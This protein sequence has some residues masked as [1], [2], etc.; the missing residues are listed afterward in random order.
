MESLG[1]ILARVMGEGGLEGRL[2]HET[3]FRSWPRVVGPLLARRCWPVS[4]KKGVL[5]VRV[6]GPLWMQELQFQKRDL[7]ERV[8]ELAGGDQIV[9]IRFTLRG[10]R[11]SAS[12]RA[13]ASAQEPLEISLSHEQRQWVENTV[14]EIQDP[15]LKARLK[16]ILEHHL[17][18][19]QRR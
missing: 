8:A 15:A 1:E 12:R 18:A 9:D 19:R 3:L 10:V 4:V 17:K 16:R 13:M 2:K 11:S 14:E 6:A 5:L 7:L